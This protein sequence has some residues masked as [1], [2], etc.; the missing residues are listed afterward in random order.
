[1]SCRQRD[2]YSVIS[3]RREEISRDSLLCAMKVVPSRSWRGNVPGWGAAAQIDLVLISDLERCCIIIEQKSFIGPADPAEVIHRSEEIK[4][5]IEQLRFRREAFHL[6]AEALLDVLQVDSAYRL[7]WVLCSDT[8][9]GASYVQDLTIPVLRTAHLTY[10]IL[11]SGFRECCDWLEN[12][13]YLPMR[14]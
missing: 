11:K 10:K 7:V 9:V 4:R 8:S 6:K 2:T 1:M 3:A 13:S 12:R 5:G 14:E